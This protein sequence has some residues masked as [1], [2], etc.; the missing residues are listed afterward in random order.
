MQH[1]WN[2]RFGGSGPDGVGAPARVIRARTLDHKWIGE[3][4]DSC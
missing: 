2:S 4:Q 3:I 1:G